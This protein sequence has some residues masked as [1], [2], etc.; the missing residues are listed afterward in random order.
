LLDDISYQQMQDLF[1]TYK[2]E[3]GIFLYNWMCSTK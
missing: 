3:F 1:Q 2:G